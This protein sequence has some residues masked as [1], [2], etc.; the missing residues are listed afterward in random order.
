MLQDIVKITKK[1][2][3]D[4]LIEEKNINSPQNVHVGATCKSQPSIF[5]QST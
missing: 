3:R 4:A 1:V 5:L 2:L